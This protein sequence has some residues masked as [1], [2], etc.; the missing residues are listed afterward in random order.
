MKNTET[1]TLDNT[2]LFSDAMDRFYDIA[3]GSPKMEATEETGEVIENLVVITG[4][5]ISNEVIFKTTPLF[6]KL[7]TKGLSQTK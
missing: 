5:T 1:H 2:K 6:L 7:K 4:D 3:N